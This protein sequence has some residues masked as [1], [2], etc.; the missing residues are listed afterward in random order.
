[1]IYLFIFIM[2][3]AI[4][5]MLGIVY[6]SNKII[7]PKVHTH[8]KIRN[9]ELENQTYDPLYLDQFRK[10]RIT[11]KSKSGCNLQGIIYHN[12]PDKFVILSHG[13]TGN[14][15]S[16]KKY[17]DIYLKRGY[18]VLMYDHRNHGYNKSSYTTLG[19]LEKY[20]V[21]VA[22]DYIFEHYRS[23][24][25]GIHGESMGAS[26]A[27]QFAAL[28]P[29]LSF[30][31]EDC[32]YDNA[33]EL[34]KIRAAE[35]HHPLL[36]L[37]TKP[38]DIYLGLFYKFKLSFIDYKVFLKDISCPMMFIHGEADDYVPYPMVHELYNTFQGKKV[39]FT[40]PEA[41]HA[42]SIH[43]DKRKYEEQVHNFL[44]QIQK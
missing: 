40:V 13:I 29:R 5:F 21:Q 39:L 14:Y 11:L 28:E 27:M 16:M 22:F 7:F 33:Y 3:F 31:I 32:G 43:M 9:Y 12:N 24:T 30:C 36:R 38:T 19:Y 41:V 8:E 26:T 15:D 37:L 20:D 23:H 1:M 44:D 18:S 34:M 25:I 2:L 17:A 6:Y 10:E 42:K 4:V 35:D